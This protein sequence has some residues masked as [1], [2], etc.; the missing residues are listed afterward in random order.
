MI[1]NEIGKL[2][3]QFWNEIPKHF[4]HVVLGEFVIMPNHTHGVLILRRDENKIG[5]EIK[6][7]EGIQNIDGAEGILADGGIGVIIPVEPL[8]CKGSTGPSN[9]I[10]KYKNGKMASISPKAGSISTIIRSYKSALSKHA[11]FINPNFEWQ[12]RFHDHIIR[13]SL[14]FDRISNYIKN[15]PLNWGRTKKNRIKK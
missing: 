7:I 9:P 13:N 11:H 5:K 12:T 1:L 6:K 3:H 4:P 8:Q 14:A 10:A 2:A 15:N